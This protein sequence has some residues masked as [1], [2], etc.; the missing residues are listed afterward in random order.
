MTLS[1]L[2]PFDGVSERTRAYMDTWMDPW[3]KVED[4]RK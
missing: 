4:I 2:D 1:D 3:V